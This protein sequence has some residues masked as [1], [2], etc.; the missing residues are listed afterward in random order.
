MKINIENKNS[1]EKKEIPIEVIEEVDFSE[2]INNSEET[3]SLNIVY[4]IV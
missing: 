4:Y 3:K 1:N 2:P